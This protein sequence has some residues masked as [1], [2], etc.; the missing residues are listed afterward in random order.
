MKR[1]LF[2]WI[3]ALA[4]PLLSVSAQVT[5][6][7]TTAGTMWETLE[8]MGLSVDTI[9]NLKVTGTINATD[10]QVFR[11]IMTSLH[12]LDLSGLN[13]STF[14]SQGCFRN[15][16]SLQNLILP[17]GMTFIENSSFEG[18]TNLVRLSFGSET[19]QDSIFVFPSTI[20][21][22]S[23]SSFSFCHGIKEVDLSACSNPT[24][25]VWIRGNSFS[26]CSNLEK[27][28]MPN[29]NYGLEYECFRWTNIKE[30]TLARN[31]QYFGNNLF[32][33]LRVIYA[34][35]PTPPTYTDSYV[36]GPLD[37]DS[38]IA[39]VPIGSKRLY[40]LADGWDQLLAN[41]IIEA[42]LQVK[43]DENGSVLY[44]GALVE[45]DGIIFH[46][47]KEVLFT[48]R[49]NAGY[50][51]ASVTVD[52]V[53]ATVTNEQLIIPA[54]KIGGV[55]RVTFAQKTLSVNA[56]IVG[57]G[58]VQLNGVSIASGYSASFA[59]GS[60]L[61]FT[62]IPQSGYTV[63]SIM[64]NGNAVALINNGTTY[65]I[66]AIDE[67]LNLVFNFANNAAIG[68]TYNVSFS[69]TGYGDVAYQ[70]TIIPSGSQLRV[71]QG[72]NILLTF[73]PREGF[74]FQKLE[75]DGA[76]VTS[77]VSNG[78]YSI[79][80][81]QANVSVSTTFY[82]DT[83]LSLSLQGGDLYNQLQTL[84]VIP[85]N[86]TALT[87]AG[88][89]LAADI[90]V[91]RSILSSLEHLDL[92][93][94]GLTEVPS[95]A[96]Q[97]MSSLKTVALPGTVTVIKESAFRSCSNL[98]EISGCENVEEIYSEAFRYCGKLKN[99]PFGSKLRYVY[100]S[101][102]FEQC[103]SFPQHIVLPASLIRLR[104][105]A[106]YNCANLVSV[107]LSACVNLENIGHECFREA[108]KLTKV[109]LP[110]EASFS[111]EGWVFNNTGLTELTIPAHVTW[112]SGNAFPNTLQVLNVEATTPI[113]CESSTF[114][115]VNL[116]TCVLN[117]PVGS[118]LSY[119]TT[120]PWAGFVNI[121][122]AGLIV[123]YNEEQGKI[124]YNGE[125]VASGK[126][127]FHNAKEVVLTIEPTTGY[128][129]I[130]AMLGATEL[131]IVN[132]T[133]TIP[134]GTISGTVAITFAQKS[135]KIYT[136]VIGNG[137][138][139]SGQ[140]NLAVA[141]SISVGGGESVQ[142]TL[143]PDSGYV[144]K[145]I[146]L[147]GEETVLH[148]EGLAF[149]IPQMG[150]DATLAFEFA[151]QSAL[152][153]TSIIRAEI[154]GE[155][156][157]SYLESPLANGDQIRVNNGENILLRFVPEGDFNLESVLLNGTDITSGIVNGNYAINNIQEDVV[158]SVKYTSLTKLYLTLSGGDLYNQM[159]SL[160]VAPQN[161]T[162]LTVTGTILESDM[163]VIRNILPS[164]EFVDLSGTG[165]TEVPA[166][167]FQNMSALKK[168]ALPETVTVIK[169]NAFQSCSN[170]EEI[171]GCE[172]V[173]VIYGWAF[174]YCGKLKNLPF[175]AKL[176]YV[177]EDSAFGECKSFPKNIVLPATLTHLRN[178][179]FRDCANL[180]SVDLSACVNLQNIGYECFRN[181][182]SLK[183]VKLPNGAEFNIEWG[184]F[185]NTG[186]EEIT[187][188]ASVTWMDNNV[189]PNTLQV[190]N[191]EASTPISC[192]SATFEQVI[193]ATCVLNV[194]AGSSLQYRLTSPWNGFVNM[195]EE[196]LLVNYEEQQGK[197]L[198][199][200]D[201]ITAGRV[202]LH[203]LK[204]VVLSVEPTTGYKVARAMLGATELP[205]VNNT[206]TIPAGTISGAVAITFAQ[207]SLKIY[208]TVIGNGTVVAG[209]RNLAATD[210]VSVGGGETM[211]FTLIPNSGYVVRSIRLNGEDA[212]LRNGG[213]SY[214]TP[215]MG[216]DAT[217]IFEFVPESALTNT[218]IISAEI[219]G[220][221]VVLYNESPLANGDQ[222]RANNGEN[223]V[224]RFVPEGDFS[225]ESVL[226]NDSDI[227]SGIVNGSY[228]INNIQED[229][230]L[231]VKY[232]SLT[233]L[234]LTLMGGDLY[235]QITSL[236]V[237]PQNVTALTITGTVLASDI[238]VIKNILP[239]SEYIDLSG[240]KLNEVPSGA[241]QNM[242]SL[243]KVILPK[244]V[245]AIRENAFQSCSNLEEISG[246]ENVEK[247]Y[248]GAFRSCEKLKN[249]PFGSKLRYVDDSFA[250]ERCNSF[251]KS[252]VLP[253]TLTNLRNYAFYNCEN[254]ESVDMSACV[255]LQYIG[256]ECFGG[257]RKL[258]V[259][260]LPSGASFNIESYT[261]NNSGL[262][263]ITIPASVT[264]IGERVFPNTLQ[265][266]NVE[267]STPISC[268]NSSFENVNQATC[269]L[270]VPMGAAQ[271]YRITSPWAS[272][273]N[274]NEAGLVV[275]YNEEQGEVSYNGDRLTSGKN[276]F[277]NARE[278][279][280]SI[281]PAIG[282][283]AILA[284]LGGTELP[285]VNNTITIP[286]G[287]ISG[288]ITITFVQKSLKI[289]TIVIGNGTVVCNQR[290]L[291]AADSVSVGG[292]ESAQFTLIPDSGYV[293]KSIRL[294][295]EESVLHNGGLNYTTPQMGEDATM[296][297]E[298]V[299]QNALVNTSVISTEIQGEGVVSYLESP[300]A[301]GD[302]IRVNN[303][304]NILLRFVPEGD[305]SLESVL[306]NGT[307]ITSGIVN[308]NYAINNIQE[309]V[310]LRVKYTSLTKLYLT[311]SGGDLYDQMMSLGVAPQSVTALTVTGT[312]LEADMTV[313]KNILPSLEYVD[314]SETKL[315]TIPS[316]SFQEKSSLKKVVLPAT[317]K[318]IKESA[319]RSCSN[320]EELSG[321]E[322]VE[323]I[324][325][326]A[327]RYC[328]KLKN[329]P[330]GA[331]L[332]YVYDSFVFEE[333]NSFPK[334]IVLPA[335][336]THLRNYAFY[337]CVNLVSVDLSACVNLQNIGH[338]CFS[339][340][341]KLT[342]V[343]LPSSASFYI[344]W[345]SFRNTGIE[346][347]II[348]ASITSIG[349]EVFPSTLQVINVE[350]ST[351][352]SCESSAF[353]QVNQ[354]ICALNVPAGSSLSYHLTSPWSN[355]L[356]I[357]E[358]GIKVLCGVEGSVFHDG[359][360][361]T[362]GSIVYHN[363]QATA[364]TI[365]PNSGYAIK[366]VKFGANEVIPSA[367]GIY[368][369]GENVE[370][371][372]LSVVFCLKKFNVAVS[373]TG[374]GSIHYADTT[375]LSN[376]IIA[377]DSSKVATLTLIPDSG[378]MV[379]RILFNN[380]E[381]IV[382]L[383][384]GIAT[385]V[386]PAISGESTVAVEF[387]AASGMS[388]MALL[389]FDIG[390]NGGIEYKNST[391]MGQT[392]IFISKGQDA[393]F[394]IVPET[395]YM[396]DNLMC[397]GLV[398]NDSIVND[399][400]TLRN[401]DSAFVR[402]S[403]KMNARLVLHV[404]TPG[405][406][407]RLV[408]AEQKELVSRVTLTGELSSSDFVTLRDE[409]KQLAVLDIYGVTNTY[410]PDRAFCTDDNSWDNPLGK[411]TLVEVR[412]PQHVN[413]I[414]Y[415]AFA[416]CSNLERVN[417]EEL[418]ELQ[419]IGDRTF[420]S[421]A[422]V[423]VNLSNTKITDFYYTFR[424]CK[425]LQTVLLPS[426]LTSLGYG[427]FERSSIQEID[428]SVCEGL[429]KIGSNSFT[430]CANLE[431]VLLP[432]GLKSIE[433]SV[434]SGCK[435]LTSFQFPS[436]LI[437]IGDGAFR[438]TNLQEVDLS[439]TGIT[440]LDNSV[441][442]DCRKLKTILLP[443][444]ITSIGD[445]AF[446]SCSMLDEIN[447]EDLTSLASLGNYCFYN[448]AITSADLSRSVISS[449]NNWAFSDCHKLEMVKLPNTITSLGEGA[450]YSTKIEY[451]NLPEGLT[452][453]GNNAFGGN[454]ILHGKLT[455]PS[456]LTT[457]NE[458]AF[459]SSDF[460]IVYSNA[461]VPP[462]LSN[463]AFNSNVTVVFVPENSV[464]A[465]KNAPGWEDY[466]ILGGEVYA[467]VTVTNPGNL[468]V[469]IM[470]Q[471]SIAPGLVT[472]LKVHGEINATD[473]AVM[474]SNMP[475][476][477]DL[478]LSD[479]EVSIIPVNAFLDKTVLMHVKLPNDLL[480]IEARAFSGCTS[481]SDTLVL[482]SNLRTIGTEAFR[483]CKNLSYLQ[484][485]SA[486]EVI[487][488]YAFY[489]CSSLTQELTF[490]D[491]FTS[492][493]EYAFAECHNLYGTIT[494][495]E[496]FYLFIGSEGYH[497]QVGNT[498]QN[499]R[500]IKRVNM[501][502]CDYVYQLPSAIFEGC[503]S[504]ERVDLPHYLERIEEHA[505]Q[506]CTSLAS[507]QFPMSLI[508]INYNAFYNCS[509]LK[510]VNLLECTELGTISDYAFC[511]CSSLKTVSLPASVNMIGG[512]AF[513]ECRALENLNVEARTP[514]DLGEYV[515]RRVNTEECILS[516]P[517]TSFNDYLTAAQWGAFVTMRK[518]INVTLDEGATLSYSRGGYAQY[519]AMRRMDENDVDSISTERGDSKIKDGSSLYVQD[520]D[521]VTF[522][523]EPDENVSINQVLFNNQDVT[524]QLQGN[525]FQ[526]PEVTQTTSFAVLLNVTGPISARD[527]SLDKNEIALKVAESQM[528][529]ATVYPHNATNKNVVWTVD[530]ESIA[531]VNQSGVVTGVSAGITNVVA[532]TDDGGFVAQC[533]VTV[534]S[535]DYYF[536]MDSASTF[537]Q[538]T[539]SIPI[540]LHN[541][542]PAS[543][544][545]CDV[546]LPEELEMTNNWGDY[547][548]QLSWRSNGHTISA[549]RRSDGSIRIVAYSMSGES[550]SGT[551]GELFYLPISTRDSAG[552]FEV[553]MRN[554]HI[555]GPNYFDF[556]A[557]DI[558][559]Q[560]RVSDYPLG[561]SN[562][563]GNVTVS[564]V[565]N[566]VNYLLEQ[567]TP[568]FVEKAADAN[569]D[570]IITVADVSATIDIIIERPSG[571][572]APT[573]LN[574]MTMNT[575]DNLTLGD[576]SIR[577]GETK[578][579]D[580][581][582]LNSVSYTAFQ[583]D[584]YLPE[585]LHVVTDTYGNPAVSL[586][587]R[588]AASHVISS[589]EVENGSIRVIAVSMNNDSFTETEGTLFSITV[590]AESD[591][592]GFDTVN[593]RGVRLVA[594]GGYEEYLAPNTSAIVSYVGEG[595]NLE[596]SESSEDLIIYSIGQQLFIESPCATTK[597]LVAVDG[598][599]M[600]LNIL[601][602]K[603]SFYIDN[604][605]VYVVDGKKVVIY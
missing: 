447:L 247:I 575:S 466:S 158:L 374:N 533:V 123:N 136:T 522:Y 294:N 291:A 98:E 553:N 569:M 480:M 196:G 398:W 166:R 77:G 484:L 586:G 375:L 128:Q 119:R 35:S 184:A 537:V 345:G 469:D 78:T 434:F 38:L 58:V 264:R 3:L 156:V 194:P 335:T 329:L 538:N 382:Q 157:V 365:I 364:F 566:T 596:N 229:I 4:M 595:T 597:Y 40:R 528:L 584:I 234:Y 509:S 521:V 445:W 214:T 576:F 113:S 126:T 536:L 341:G 12:R 461:V 418:H 198:Y 500:N 388:D 155:G 226:L 74:V 372:T 238:T 171:S 125:K 239:A 405:T 453:I 28:T 122:E 401:V 293:V 174:E 496:E 298:F 34:E 208:T 85:Q 407:T 276:L 201:K 493:G 106:F 334:N 519:A 501:L 370:S 134:A 443:N 494:F 84:G 580:V 267:S 189:F 87:V 495:N 549:A 204:E 490:P 153:N 542:G 118:S 102:A 121:N 408:S 390:E 190:L 534:M 306:L 452:T 20:T 423:N 360:K 417:F 93:G 357:T 132:N 183:E 45:N 309:D 66:D 210:S 530:N 535:N 422:L 485:D 517:T 266:L 311:L 436:T 342:E 88:T 313:I 457:I 173:E 379:K 459:G 83:H 199:N 529:T 235:S 344:E 89:I 197:V 427:A 163:T 312:I 327:F 350:A 275:N 468:A 64:C 324:Y 115:Q 243:K 462:T 7:V 502:A 317:V 588:K 265:I 180:V 394:A 25:K 546:Y 60:N 428:L 90:A 37:K 377:V 577:A 406:L 213:L 221:G 49:P 203:H 362:D 497:S 29:A 605:G 211:Q 279:V 240:T 361:V 16:T 21:C 400:F 381:A 543:G 206:I 435:K 451:I 269:V 133:I 574:L 286:A 43:Y 520:Q 48:V 245:I 248:E 187:I 386:T 332:R 8:N 568:R 164:L 167:A 296:A 68:T 263:E 412:L 416:G 547:G 288:T 316:G 169:E 603:N 594:N 305:F 442:N 154:Q 217:M 479:A 117:V 472:H 414:N 297:F 246:C 449:I 200:G 591:V 23:Y 242:S 368:T 222:L 593:L 76:D 57:Q 145:S 478:D 421:T 170:L 100:D 233:K 511:G 215:Q 363:Q 150:E 109:T 604:K 441:F 439:A 257:T 244:T 403:F 285:I 467:E 50:E 292:G 565:T 562:G 110:I 69:Q 463:Y 321:C 492:L 583:C 503:T 31:C 426:T 395:G 600:L 61:A 429:T 39:Y 460:S 75:V 227:T 280:L 347:I 254:L 135:L 177:Y 516:I 277:H 225:L 152:T 11:K 218:S 399:Q 5:V 539:V 272:F 541:S 268:V 209:Q 499:C 354:A 15:M 140:R 471:D 17:A 63:Q 446:G 111:I 283:E 557:P 550:F 81:I 144:V 385:Y 86:V 444:T 570:K 41:N 448:T 241:F 333:C 70:N 9:T 301:D 475:V 560:I 186:I 489:G 256:W 116:A 176:R 437:S 162:A 349:G 352:I 552:V 258:K 366:T 159:M 330:F 470:E 271:T 551:E 455:L 558:A 592:T 326:E 138:V 518:A 216:E 151:A 340:A 504:L 55:I 438:Y 336:L 425:K 71:N 346:E 556:V 82:S 188:P 353:N 582:L 389:T 351:P 224:L 559:T 232:T 92:S 356:N 514:A 391:L 302:Q 32:D 289:Y 146:R 396:V 284:M 567:Y 230:T 578:T 261:F 290:N 318:V 94:T 36:F 531:H 219:Q 411:M 129:A 192:G 587:S 207:K 44:N 19:V 572:Y 307:D 124:S 253:A 54:G 465:Y 165:L 563:D 103:N 458:W 160:G 598:K 464:S 413:N 322:N 585:G 72:E 540:S 432:I 26:S 101:F 384:N 228:S 53:A 287:T 96:F 513:E 323:E 564:D 545:Q 80:N 555:A 262:T 523:I 178:Y 237:A 282:Y 482:P 392:S 589:A 430:D 450:F 367:E 2:A 231:R 139:L 220:D 13:I 304:E 99:L 602:G 112:I 191:V 195:N 168:V 130:L 526:T 202:I 369:I 104:N 46:D 433:G 236:G 431:N 476:L 338:E 182:S 212:I 252:I 419:Y 328:R 6:N 149:T 105:E 47:A 62:L 456:T 303:G 512:H 250:F 30:F 473:F 185:R 315:A 393:T 387:Q 420:A 300:L 161:V 486:L 343:R 24:D 255:N 373:S 175:G 251:P 573:R 404:E 544:F 56:T 380:E 141:D 147:N 454:T 172:N 590:E 424:D 193:Q 1:K 59:G 52:D 579:I 337:N 22:I 440:R 355:F 487:R 310:V 108:S 97:N 477:Y 73:T 42:G 320:L 325:S 14:P 561:D 143:I 33:K 205:I 410:I 488:N 65:T 397:N 359:K 314:L 507:I 506:N 308:G 505:F 51:I 260:K 601:P 339:G 270:N 281:K 498:F 249:L 376:T 532:T 319:F 358:S 525:I 131:P 483:N 127:L 554:I 481:L 402:A 508:F 548:V 599:N 378:Y 274:I 79:Q 142:F 527:V 278:V 510:S 181:I 120:S 107:D 415:C 223:I 259:V 524:N 295:G 10:Y 67:N 474:R 571:S 91:I 515:F 95:G 114:E 409:F 179:A 273:V 27:A 371:D 299:S 491:Q 348:P 148:N 383:R 581:E 18:C 137:R 331:K